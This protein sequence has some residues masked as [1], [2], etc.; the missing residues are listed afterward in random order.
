MILGKKG[1]KFTC[2]PSLAKIQLQYRFSSARYL[3]YSVKVLTQFKEL[4]I[5]H[6]TFVSASEGLWCSNLELP[7]KCINY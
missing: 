2:K 3:R 1:N 5:E 7:S 4:C 6:A